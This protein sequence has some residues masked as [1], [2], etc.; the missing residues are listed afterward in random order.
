VYCADLKTAS[1][2]IR[3]ILNEADKFA[4]TLKDVDRLLAGPNGAK[5]EAS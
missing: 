1:R 3:Y 4:V 2:D 5:I